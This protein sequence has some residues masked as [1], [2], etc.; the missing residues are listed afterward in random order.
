MKKVFRLVLI[1][2]LITGLAYAKDFE[3]TK[4]AGPYSVIVKMD[5]NPPIVGDNGI[6]ITLKDSTGKTVKDAKVVVE[7]VMPA[8]PGMPAMRYRDQPVL[9]GE[10]YKGNLNFSMGGAWILNVKI[11]HGEKTDTVK[12][13]VDVS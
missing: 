6:S 4:Q 1:A 11:T 10:T 7:Y 5:K 13:S 3:I 12:L 8:M 2:L 9:K